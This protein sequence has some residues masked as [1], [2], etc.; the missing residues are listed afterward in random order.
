MA[1]EMIAAAIGATMNT[2]IWNSMPLTRC[3]RMRPAIRTFRIRAYQE[4][5]VEALLESRDGR[6][7]GDDAVLHV[8]LGVLGEGLGRAEVLVFGGDLAVR[9]LGGEF[10]SFASARA[11][12][13]VV[14]I[15]LRTL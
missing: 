6:V 13:R 7:V 8:G 14:R 15:W 1:P 9:A 3:G 2:P 10:Q 12:F 5:L 11:A 4:A